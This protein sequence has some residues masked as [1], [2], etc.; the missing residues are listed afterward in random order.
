[1]G[2]FDIAVLTIVSFFTI[3]GL[4][5]GLISEL[6]VLVA[7]V[8]GYAAAMLFHVPLQQKLISLFPSLPDGGAKVLAFV[9]LFV[10]VNIFVRILG[11]MLNKIA[12]FTFLQPVNKIAGALF[13]FTKVTLS[14]SIILY[15]LQAIPGSDMLLEP[16]K[17]SNSYT[18]GPVSK[19]APMLY[20]VFY[21]DSGKSFDEAVSP[22]K[23][24]PDSTDNS[25]LD[26]L[27]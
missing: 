9:L 20:D 24:I 4:F 21:S 22:G 16:I 5:R 10:A 15:L 18:Y 1:M 14:L 23:L 17:K 6:M 3:R 12:T 27:K 8:F 11:G 13:G 19:F 2:Y 7:L 26:L 25:L